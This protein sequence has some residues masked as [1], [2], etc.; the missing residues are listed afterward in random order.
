MVRGDLQRGAIIHIPLVFKRFLNSAQHTFWVRPKGFE[1]L[2]F[3][4]CNKNQWK[5]SQ[6]FKHWPS[7]WRTYQYSTGFTM[8]LKLAR[9]MISMPFKASKIMNFYG[10]QNAMKTNN[11]NQIDHLETSQNTKIFKIDKDY[12]QIWLARFRL[13]WLARKLEFV[14]IL[15]A[16]KRF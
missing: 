9:S 4:K 2:S 7:E 1:L 11:T 16:A 6:T 3:T 5:A 12:N 8:F 13:I 14:W 15:V 10:L